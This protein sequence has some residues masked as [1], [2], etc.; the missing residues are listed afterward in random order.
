MAFTG[1]VQFIPR[2]EG[3]MQLFQ[4]PATAA[5]L[6][7]HLQAINLYLGRNIFLEGMCLCSHLIT[8]AG[9]IVVKTPRNVAH[10]HVFMCSP[11]LKSR[12]VYTIERSLI[13]S[14]GQNYS[15]PTF[16]SLILAC[17]TGPLGLL[18]HYATKAIWKGRSDTEGVKLQSDGGTLT[19]MPYQEVWDYGK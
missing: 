1:K 18:S 4:K 2:L 11:K 7:V 9:C 15:I 13:S 8:G 10:V 19:L 17:F 3:I 16:H 5:S 14:S 12:F 6:I